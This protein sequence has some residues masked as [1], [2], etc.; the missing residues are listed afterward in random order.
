MNQENWTKAFLSAP[1]LDNSTP[2]PVMEV[3]AGRPLP[4]KQT[5]SQVTGTPTELTGEQWRENMQWSLDAQAAY[6]AAY[7]DTMIAKLSERQT[8][9]A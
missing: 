9:P 8:D 7:A 1:H 3:F 5:L 4:H 6:A 2:L